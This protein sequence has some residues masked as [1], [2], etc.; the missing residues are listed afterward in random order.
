MNLQ[1]T[2][3]FLLQAAAIITVCLGVNVGAQTVTTIAGTHDLT[4]QTATAIS[5]QAVWSVASDKSGNLYFGIYNQVYNL[6][7]T[8]KLTLIAGN[9]VDGIPVDG[10][11]ATETPIESV[12]SL[13][14]DSSSNLYIG[15]RDDSLVFKVTAST[16]KISIYAG[17][18]AYGTSGDG[19]A[20]TLAELESPEGLAVDSSSNLYIA[21]SSAC[22]VRK[23]DTSGIITTAA[24]T[25]GSCATLGSNILSNGLLYGVEDVAV[26]SSGNL[27][28]TVYDMIVKSSGGK[29]TIVAGC[30]DG[31]GSVGANC[32]F[33]NGDGQVATNTYIYPE[34]VAVDSAG[35]LYIGDFDNYALRKVDANTQ[36]I[37]TVAGVYGTKESSYIASGPAT[38]T[39]L[40]YL[41]KIALDGDGNVY[42]ADE[43]FEV[44]RKVNLSGNMLSTAVGNGLAYSGDGGLA[45]AA[46]F[47]S[48]DGL[49]GTAV[50]TAGNIYIADYEAAVVRKIDAKTGIISTFA[51]TGT[52]G[53]SG[54]D[55]AAISAKIAHPIGLAFDAAGN[56][57]ITDAGNYVI[58]KV[59]TAGV[60]ST[61]AG[62]GTE[63]Y[64]GDGRAATAAEF[65]WPMGLAFDTAGNLYVSD[66]NASV[67]RKID[68]DGIIHTAVGTGTYGYSGDGGQATAAEIEWPVQVGFDNSGNLIF[69]DANAAVIREVYLADANSANY[70]VIQTIAG[71]GSANYSST[72]TGALSV[73]FTDPYGAFVDPSG[74]LL[75]ADTDANV[76]YTLT[77]SS[78]TA[79]SS[80]VLA[81]VAGTG[82][83]G[84][85][86]DGGAA[87]SAEFSAP[88]FINADL[89]GGLLISD[90]S[91]GRLRNLTNAVTAVYTASLSSNTLGF[92]TQQLSTNATA[93]KTVTLTNTSPSK[94]LTISLVAI[95]GT[96]ATDFTATNTCTTAAVA[97]GS[98]CTVTV[99][100]TA[101]QTGSESATL[102]VI[103]DA[104]SQA[105]TLSGAGISFSAP[106]AA[107]GGSTSATIASGSTATYSLQ[108]AATGGAS[109]S[110]SL[111]LSLTCSG[112][113]TNATCTVS[114][115]S[116]TTTL[117]TPGAFTVTVATTK[118]TTTTNSAQG[119]KIASNSSG[120]WPT[121]VGLAILPFGIFGLIRKRRKLGG[122][123]LLLLMTSFLAA[124]GCGGGSKKSTTTTT[125]GTPAGTYTLTVK[126]TSGSVSQTTNLTLTVN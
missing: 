48:Y 29:L 67:I 52:S 51:G 121:G 23:V 119:T 122:L 125:S 98:T 74:K 78:F 53:Y 35:N 94:A 57:Y 75:V 70:G 126:A 12:Y 91:N 62:N 114:P 96:N 7:S 49:A 2:H 39:A 117:A 83:A 22:S 38:K 116:V 4:G 33:G 113:P 58:R 109:T 40:G 111:S 84:Y 110:D 59:D 41:H 26:D 60:I 101:T 3:A 80:G 43:Y 97:A 46:Q 108:V 115:A 90:T 64:S 50:D 42:L 68:T 13:A 71:G 17:N 56:L 69:T 82:T 10:A 18:G 28:M 45:T 14:I 11:T 15:D 85:S 124:N 61:F 99:T 6:D 107:S 73:K 19:G 5:G 54:D 37:S 20:A 88:T 87:T 86:G 77:G 31:T 21:D 8:G 72:N 81:V 27:Y 47:G 102:T 118:Y 36:I 30:D 66:A 79:P 93:S 104:G 65:E 95:T 89:K 123:L 1:K 25:S 34:S 32:T 92:S 106:A 105:A 55:G 76:V 112:A 16:G 120:F 24:G 103:D 100:F 63:G 9:G 44:I